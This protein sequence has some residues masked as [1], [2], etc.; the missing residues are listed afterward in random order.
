MTKKEI[1]EIR[2]RLSPQNHQIACI[3]GCYVNS[4]GQVISAFTRSLPAISQEETEKYLS[5]FRRTLSGE[6]EQSLH[7][8]DFSPTQV[9]SSPQ[10]RLLMQLRDCAL[11]DEAAVQ[12][13][14]DAVR[15]AYTVEEGEHYLILLMHDRYDVPP[16]GS[17][18]EVTAEV[19]PY[20]LCSVCPVKMTKPALIYDAS[21]NDFCDREADW[22]VEAPQAGF[23]FP[24]FDER[25]ANIYNALYYTREAAAAHEALAEAVFGTPLPMPAKRQQESFQAILQNSL[26]DECSYEVMHSVHEQVM[27]KIEEQKAD[28]AAQEP[29]RMDS[30][31]VAAILK[32]CGVTDERRAAFE[33]AFDAEFGAAALNAAAVS[34]PK[35]FQV[36]TPDVVI[37]VSPARSD[38]VQ[39]RII[40]GHPY[41]LIRA[42]EGVEVNG[43]DVSIR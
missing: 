27:E 7:T 1:A 43:V 2:R 14:F 3:K 26:G 29:P 4:Q 17:G 21:R 24:A 10:H 8:I 20:I 36:R 34:S 30:R 16:R 25:T 6:P 28:K 40:D 41:I 18:G 9:L 19:F 23:L 39:T 35:Q 37:R 38:L 15:A 42:E 22:A 12:A 13:F 11:R 32:D 33:K 5:L 31:E